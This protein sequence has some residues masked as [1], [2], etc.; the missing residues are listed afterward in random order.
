MKR[1]RP[2]VTAILALLATPGG[3]LAN[4]TPSFILPSPTTG[5]ST[6]ALDT[7]AIK[8]MYQQVNQIQGLATDIE[9]DLNTGGYN[10]PYT[11]ERLDA[12]TKQFTG[13]ANIP[14]P[15]LKCK[16][17][18]GQEGLAIAKAEIAVETVAGQAAYAVANP[19]GDTSIEVSKDLKLLTAYRAS[20]SRILFNK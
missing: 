5:T 20:V 16:W 12:A 8:A 11:A 7:A 18:S 6:P 13:A 10:G 2:A 9:K 3:A 1:N 17:N 19:T 14:N 4:Q 15:D